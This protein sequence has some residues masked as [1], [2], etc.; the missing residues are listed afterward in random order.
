MKVEILIVK[1]CPRKLQ[2]SSHLFDLF[3][4]EAFALNTNSSVN[5]RELTQLKYH[6]QVIPYASDTT[7]HPIR[8]LV[9]GSQTVL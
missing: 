8:L 1:I 7:F 9:S 6:L 3:F 5:L 4:F 2:R